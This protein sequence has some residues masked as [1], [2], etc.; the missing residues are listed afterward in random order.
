MTEPGFP[1]L[2]EQEGELIV[3]LSPFFDPVKLQ[4]VRLVRV[5]DAGLWVENHKFN[6]EQM[7][8]TFGISSSPKTLIFFLPW[9]QIAT[10]LGSVDAP[11]LSDEALG[12]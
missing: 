5:E 6:V 10:I 1:S 2:K 12:L 7:K 4:R 8:K 3:I 11:T 9:H